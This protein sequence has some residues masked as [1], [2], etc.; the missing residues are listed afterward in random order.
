MTL[1]QTFLDHSVAAAAV[2]LL[3]GMLLAFMRLLKGPD[4]ADRIVALDL[5]SIL[6]V[7]LLAIFAIYADES[8]FL[9]VAIAYALVAFLGTVALARFR[10]RT[11]ARQ[12][13]GDRQTK[14][15]P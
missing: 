10:M 4:D 3:T 9:D 12:T 1:P 8:S 7:A 13:A 14:E 2:L 5:I 6:L 11:D 15:A